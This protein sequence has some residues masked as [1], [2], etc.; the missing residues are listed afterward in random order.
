MRLILGALFL[1]LPAAY[2]QSQLGTGAISGTIH[3]S[4]GAVIVG[5]QV[6][7][8]QPETG[9]S[10]QVKSGATGEY[11]APVLPTGIYR[12]R[13]VKAGFSTLDQEGITV[14]VGGTTNVAS[15]LKV[16]EVAETITV[17][18]APAINPSQTDISSLVDSSEIRNLPING[19]RYYDFALL[20][21]GVT[22]DGIL[23]LLSFRGTSGNFDNYMVEG[24]DD[25]QAYFSEN[26]GRYRAPSTVSANAVEEF[27]VG[28]G[29]YLAE[30]GRATGGSVN[31]VLRSGVNQFHADGFYYYRDQDFGA[32][33]PLATIKPP[34][35]RQQLGGSL[36]GPVRSNRLFYFVNYDQQIRN[37]PLVIEDLTNALQ[38]GKPVLPP[39]PTSAQQ[40]TYATQLNAFNAGVAYVMK[41]F[42]GG[43]PGNQQSRTMGNNIVLGKADYLINSSNTLSTFFNYMRSSGERAIQTPIVLGNVGRNGTDDVRIDSYNARLTST[44]GP[45]RVNEVR[46]QWSRD[47]EFEIADQPPP[48]VYANG[49]GNFSFGRATFLQRY[50]LP[51]ERRLQFVDNFSYTTGRHAFK[52]GGEVNRVHDFINNPTEFGGV[53]TYPS[54]FALGED[55]VTPGARNYSSFIEDFGL[56]QYAYDTID[57]AWF[58]QDQWRPLHRLTINYGLRWDKQTMPTPFAPNPAIPLTQKFPTDWKS[59]GPRVGV[60]YD[61]TGKGST[62]IRGG[63]GIYYGRIPNGIIAYALQNT[64]LTDP[65]KALVSLTLQPTDPNAPVYPNILAS[66]PTGESLSTTSTL[67][68]SNFAR[69]RVQDYTIGVQQQLP[70][71][72]V[73]TASYAH[74]YGDHLEIVVDS[75]LPA[76]QFTRTYQLPDGTTFAVPFSAGVIKT[77]AGATVSVNA[78]R[79]NPSQGANNVNTSDGTSWYN[80]LIMDVHRRLS[81][82]LQ[83]NGAFT[84]AKAENTAGSGNGNGAAAETAFNGGTPQNQFNLGSDRGLSPL[85]Q[86]YRLV[87]SA[88]WEPR[89]R[90]LRGFR[91]SAIETIETGRPIGE[92]VSVPSIPFVAPDGNT[93]NGFGG[94]LGQGSGGDRNL[95]PTVGR[96][97]LAGPANYA[98]ALRVSREFR[99]TERIRVEALAEGF[100]VFNHSNYNG[101]NDTLYTAAATSNTTP[102]ATPIVLTPTAGFNAPVS[103]SSPPDGTNARRLQ[104]ALRFRF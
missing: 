19:R 2:A 55:L 76:P 85:D 9:L 58:L 20:A 92:F 81:A 49:S 45:Q 25:N 57:Y 84:W 80:A 16:G 42:P 82:G 28:Q 61:L 34:E 98:L 43:A 90:G 94:L 12:I 50:A 77:A 83:V 26:R 1:C 27:Q 4:S 102:L 11:L 79:P 14:D 75:N 69:P 72:L 44:L 68:A 93:Y 18:S 15:T 87:M 30:F 101:F 73:L 33:D 66:V 17:N 62:V 64:G 53:F 78:S 13:I 97:T 51:D 89:L 6:T 35:R 48:E 74:T 36:S 52:F 24:N 5:A 37:F 23:G 86:R 103:D 39:N 104:L 91:L 95:L 46:F 8:Q 29:A 3:D 38:S 71:G 41:Q 32:R 100:N 59:F 54:T 22:R 60:A 47:F 40:A 99:M 88:V 70:L 31:M 56:A 65:T 96:N 67:L 10:R 21:P 7:I 63:Y